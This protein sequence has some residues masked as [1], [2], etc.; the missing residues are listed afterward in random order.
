MTQQTPTEAV[1]YTCKID[2]SN[3]DN[4]AAASFAITPVGPV[5]GVPALSG[6]SATAR[7]SGMTL[8][9]T[10]TLSAHLIGASG[11]QYD[12]AMDIPCVNRH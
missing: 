12:G 10:Y 2:P 11:Q 9:V 1:D 4:V 8:G 5:I 6:I 3:G 7:V